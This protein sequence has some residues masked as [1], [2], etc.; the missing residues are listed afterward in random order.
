M[1]QK[2]FTKFKAVIALLFFVSTIS[3]IGVVDAS[4]EIRIISLFHIHTKEELRIVYKKNGKYIP[5][6]LKKLN[7][8][9]RDWRKNEA[10][11]I[12]PKAIDIAWEMH[13][14]LG[15]LMPIYVI[16]GYRAR[17]TNDMLRSMGG[18]QASN[19]QHINGKAI[20]LAFPDVPIRRL[21]YSA[22]IKEVGGVGYYPT[23]AIPFVHIDT[24]QVRSWPRM[25]HDE[26]ALLFPRGHSKYFSAEGLM[27]KPGDFFEAKKRQPQLALQVAQFF[28]KLEPGNNRLNIASNEFPQFVTLDTI[29]NTQGDAVVSKRE[30]HE[31]LYGKKVRDQNRDFIP[32]LLREPK[33]VERSSHFSLGPTNEDR[34]KLTALVNLL[35]PSSHQEEPRLKRKPR[36]VSN[37]K[38]EA[39]N[40][41][42]KNDK[43]NKLSFNSLVSQPVKISRK[44]STK[45]S[46]ISHAKYVPSGN[47]STDTWAGSPPFDEDH[48]DELTYQPF[49]ILPLMTSTP[50][51]DDPALVG[52]LHPNIHKT[53]E[54]IDA[55]GYL[56]P[57][58]F[59]PGIQTA[60]LLYSQKFTG[61]VVDLSM[62]DSET[63]EDF[64]KSYGFLKRVVTTSND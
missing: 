50:S 63:E 26:L 12:D 43:E 58:R 46:I 51:P 19:S 53:L 23:S 57:M 60:V 38:G 64:L 40:I 62:V 27:L 56:L 6:A 44:D 52:L 42:T 3:M 30:F 49:P 32:Q 2:G 25:P 7:W 47:L 20:D 34:N 48:P 18:G 15:S 14:E 35:D 59:R 1:K 33:L 37:Q 13:A 9:L 28:D 61:K 55:E 17:E 5:E 24:G 4:G 29:E 41:L 36:L 39:T 10:I 54:M 16:C 45:N 8:L 21:R 31:K 11:E 22:M